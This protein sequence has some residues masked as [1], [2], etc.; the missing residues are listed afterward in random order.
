M[1][2]GVVRPLARLLVGARQALD[3][4]GE[5]GVHGVVGTG[6]LLSTETAF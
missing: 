5:R 2:N 1:A 6:W 3:K 4:G